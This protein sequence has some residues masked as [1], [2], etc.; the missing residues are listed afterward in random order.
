MSDLKVI[1]Y[2]DDT[3]GIMTDGGTCLI[4]PRVAVEIAQS[5]IDT[6]KEADPTLDTDAIR[7]NYTET[8]RPMDVTLN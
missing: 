7:K 4:T 1:L 6:A 8:H 2:N 5:L 3:V